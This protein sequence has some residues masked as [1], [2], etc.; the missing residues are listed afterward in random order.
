MLLPGA[1]VNAATEIGE[2]TIVNT[3]A[4]I[5]HDG[6]I[7]AFVHVLRCKNCDLSGTYSCRATAWA[8]VS[9][10]ASWVK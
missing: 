1:V 6:R 5:D 4:S 2:G 10:F 3:N 8:M 9:A 7:G